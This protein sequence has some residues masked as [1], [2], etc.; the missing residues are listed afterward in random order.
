MTGDFVIQVKK[1]GRNRF[2]NMSSGRVVKSDLDAKKY[3]TSEEAQEQIDRY[4]KHDNNSE[5]KVKELA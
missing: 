1:A 5:F 4:S 3:D 2:Q